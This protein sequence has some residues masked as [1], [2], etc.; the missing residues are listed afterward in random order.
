MKYISLLIA[1]LLFIALTGCSGKSSDQAMNGPESI[2]HDAMEAYNS[3]RYVTALKHFATLTD[4]FPFSQYSL[5][6]ELKSADCYYHLGRYTEGIAAYQDFEEG[7]PTNEAVPYTM[8]QVAMSHY[9]QL[10]TID[11]DP[12]SAA[13]AIAIFNKLMR[14]YPQ[15]SYTDEAR[16]RIKAARNFLAN[17]EMYVALFYIKTDKLKQAETR[18]EYIL[19]NYPDSTVSSEAENTLAILKTG[20]KPSGSWKDWIPELGV[21]DWETLSS[22]KGGSGG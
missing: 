18:L 11:R 3:G 22:F 12:A 9:R 4:R 10:D 15:S 19:D 17:H 8:F 6:A 5:M 14:S 1:P 20:K 2:V 16:S 13:N 7:H 21:P